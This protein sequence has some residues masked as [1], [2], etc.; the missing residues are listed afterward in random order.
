MRAVP[1]TCEREEASNTWLVVVHRVY[2]VDAAAPALEI[3][4]FAWAV[5]DGVVFAAVEVQIGGDVFVL[6]DVLRGQA[7]RQD[8]RQIISSQVKPPLLVPS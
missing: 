7:G 2:C 5:G 6:D 3:A 1:C 8:G 4:W